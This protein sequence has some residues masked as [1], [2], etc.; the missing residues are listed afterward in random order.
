MKFEA[1]ASFLSDH[2]KLSDSEKAKFRVA[3]VTLNETYTTHLESG[4][5]DRPKWPKSLRIRD[6]EGAPGIW[7]LT[8]SFSGPD[9]RATFEYFDEGRERAIRWRRI[10]GHEIFKTP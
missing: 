7:E 8:W 1:T 10:G 6:V 3:V 2:S 9:G 4:S 5:E